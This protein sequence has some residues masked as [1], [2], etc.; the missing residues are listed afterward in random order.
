MGEMG[1]MREYRVEKIAN[2]DRLK[3]DEFRTFSRAVA[4][5][6]TSSAMP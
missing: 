3:K 1:A 6:K 4:I 2:D 5:G